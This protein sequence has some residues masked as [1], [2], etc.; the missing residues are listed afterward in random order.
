MLQDSADDFKQSTSLQKQLINID[1]FSNTCN[2]L[3]QQNVA[4]KVVHALCHVLNRHV[5]KMVKFKL[6]HFLDVEADRYGP[7]QF[8]W[9]IYS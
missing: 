6:V 4:L 7:F 2:V 9:G 8:C 1:Q 5:Y 3:L